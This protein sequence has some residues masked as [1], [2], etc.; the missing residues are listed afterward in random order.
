M[1]TK[2]LRN[3]KA[4]ALL[5]ILAVMAVVVG[6]G[7]SSDSTSGGDTLSVDDYGK[8][9]SDEFASFNTDF[10]QL[11]QQAASPDSK[12]AYLN[13]VDQL[14]TRVGETIDKLSGLAVPSEA[15]QFNDDAVAALESLQSSFDPIKT[16]VQSNDQAAVQ[17]AATDL[18]TAAADFEQQFTA[19]DKEAKDA[20]IPITNLASPT[21]G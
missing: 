11:G 1:E 13:T 9:V 18:Q 19:L 14:Q 10:T 20:G 4:V 7:G 12:D 17:K 5:A 3:T 2:N 16:A 6:C 15:Q 8:Q 21:G